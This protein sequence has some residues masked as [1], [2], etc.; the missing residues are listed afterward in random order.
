MEIEH[1]AL[2][3]SNPIEMADWYVQNL[4]MTITLKKDSAPHTR[5]LADSTGSVMLEIYTHPPDQIPA[6][7][8]MDPFVLHIA[9][10]AK[11]PDAAKGSLVAAGAQFVSESHLEDGSRLVMLRDPWG[12]AIQLVKRAKPWSHQVR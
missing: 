5:F 9:F 2:N 6:Y 7:S 4:G 12:L 3:V 10:E 11:D 1:V 8:E